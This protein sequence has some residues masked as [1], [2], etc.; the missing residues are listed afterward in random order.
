MYICVH[1][2][3]FAYVRV[4]LRTFVLQKYLH[5][6]SYTISKRYNAVHIRIYKYVSERWSSF[7]CVSG[8]FAYVRVR[9][10]MFAYVSVGYCTICP[11][12]NQNDANVSE[13]PN[14]GSYENVRKR[15]C[16]RT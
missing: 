3:S 6:S 10:C 13:K 5:M 8:T 12:R 16:D 9:S 4:R 14:D 7:L 15:I 11:N 2:H 1:S